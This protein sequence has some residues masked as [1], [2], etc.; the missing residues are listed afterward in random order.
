MFPAAGVEVSDDYT[1][2]AWDD[3]VVKINESIDA[4]ALEFRYVVDESS[5]SKLYAM[6]CIQGNPAKSIILNTINRLTRRAMKW[7]SSQ[8]T[9]HRW[10]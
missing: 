5:G 10:K 3:F 7:R 9:T 1:S 4:F 6:V 2:E 8:R